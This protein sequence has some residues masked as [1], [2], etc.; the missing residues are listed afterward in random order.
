MQKNEKKNGSSAS[1]PLSSPFHI[2]IDKTA[3]GISISCSGVKGISEFS[4]T[5]IILKMPHFAL[6]IG[7]KKLCMTVFEGRSVEIIGKLEGVSF[8]YAE[9]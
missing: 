3:K 5:E 4:D 9:S 6:K 7:G 1:F 2:E 8:I